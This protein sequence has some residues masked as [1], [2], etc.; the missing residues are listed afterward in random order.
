MQ[1]ELFRPL[2]ERLPGSVD[3]RAPELLLTLLEDGDQE[4]GE[5]LHKVCVSLGRNLRLLNEGFAMA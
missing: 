2:L 4:Q 5:K 3:L 1:L